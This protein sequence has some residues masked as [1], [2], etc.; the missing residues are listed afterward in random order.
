VPTLVLLRHAKSAWP[1][2][3]DQDRPLAARGRR[4]APA[5]GRWLRAA[6]LLPDLVVCSTAKRARQTWRLAAAE[7]TGAGENAGGPAVV[8]EPRVYE[9]SAAGLLGLVREVRDSVQTLLLVGHE[10]AMSGL[11]LT[12]GGSAV[13]SE[14]LDRVRAKFPTSAIAVLSFTGAWSG[15][16]PG[17][18]RLIRFVTPGGMRD[19]RD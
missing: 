3:P 14:A 17:G 8:F 7:L 10:P 5:A 18:A 9:A 1:G 4:D 2:V 19:G 16:G 6:G 13:P 15:L 12:L 11:A